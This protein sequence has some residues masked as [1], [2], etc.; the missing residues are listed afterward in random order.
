MTEYVI[1]QLEDGVEVVRDGEPIEPAGG[2][3]Q[4]EVTRG[5]GIL[6][7]VKIITGFGDTIEIT[8][9]LFDVVWYDGWGIDG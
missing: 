1:R 7:N 9:E 3:K 5:I 4:V 6:P 8:I 2:I